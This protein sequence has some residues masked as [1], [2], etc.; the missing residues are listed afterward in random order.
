MST[1][2]GAPVPHH[3]VWSSASRLRS[4]VRDITRK[5]MLDD[6]IVEASM[7]RKVQATMAS[8]EKSKGGMVSS[9]RQTI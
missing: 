8:I 3:A 7:A 6:T 1:C 5:A 4:S 2:G 9:R